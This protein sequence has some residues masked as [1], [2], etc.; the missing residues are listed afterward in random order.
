MQGLNVFKMALIQLKPGPNKANNIENACRMVMEASRE[1][2]SVVV[3]PECFNSPYGTEYFKEYAEIVEKNEL[4]H[5]TLALSNVAKEANVYLIGGSIPE[6]SA[7]SQKFYNTCT[8][9]NENGEMIA[10]HRKIHLYDVSVPGKS[11]FYESQVLSAGDNLTAFETP[12]GKI[13]VA[14]CY[15]LRFPE[16]AMVAARKGCVAMIYPGAFNSNTYPLHWEMLLKARAIDNMIFVAGCSPA[17][18]L[19]FSYHAWGHSTI[20]GPKG[21]IKSTCE[22]DETIVYSDIDL[23]E[24]SEIR[25]NIPIY[26]QRRFDL[27]TDISK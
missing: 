14:I 26:S 15:D 8:V 25:T 12:W 21:D 11:S 27:Y 9:W 17:R 18:D 5:T 24:I 6:R 2:A 20:V 7:D 23:E 3:L 1:G 4:G 19:D 22:F 16:L 10:K 13:G